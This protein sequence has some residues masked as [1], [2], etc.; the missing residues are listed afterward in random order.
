M[1]LLVIKHFRHIIALKILPEI[2]LSSM[3]KIAIAEMKRE[4]I[5]DFINKIEKA[6]NGRYFGVKK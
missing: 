1:Q 4:V 6:K 5:V 3:K 2:L